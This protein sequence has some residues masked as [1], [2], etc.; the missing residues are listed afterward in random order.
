MPKFITIGYGDDADYQRTAVRVRDR[1]HSHDSR[2]RSEGGS[3]GSQV[4]L[5]RCAIPT[6][7]G[8]T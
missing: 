5:F 2:L 8:S 4:I 7:L 6:L 3:W 1:A